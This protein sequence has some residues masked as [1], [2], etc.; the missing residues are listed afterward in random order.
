MAWLAAGAAGHSAGALAKDAR[1]QGAA[2]SGPGRAYKIAA[3]GSQRRSHVTGSASSTGTLSTPSPS[4]IGRVAIRPRG[5]VAQAR[6][7]VAPPWWRAVE[8]AQAAGG[9]AAER[10][11]SSGGGGKGG[12]GLDAVHRAPIALVAVLARF[13]RAG[14]GLGRP[15]ASR[16][17]HTNSRSP[18]CR[19]QLPATPACGR[20]SH[21]RCAQRAR[22]YSA[23]QRRLPRSGAPPA[24]P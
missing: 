6:P 19:P 20:C 18:A 2:G 4:N 22:P 21:P 24:A 14:W 3:S 1:M 8:E 9:L 11:A 7:T 16:R 15:G 12:G 17:A 5:Q 10:R 23:I 13:V